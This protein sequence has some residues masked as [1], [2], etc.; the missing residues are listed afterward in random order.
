VRNSQRVFFE[1]SD[2]IRLCG[3]LE[4]NRLDNRAYSIF[5]HCFTCTKDLKAIVRISRRLAENRIAVLRFDFAGLGES[6]G[7]FSDTNFDSNLRDIRAAVEFLIRNFQAPKLL[8]GHSLGGAA[9]MTLAEE[10]ES[11][12]ALIT[13][14][15][16]STTEHLI[17]HLVDAAP[18]VLTDGEGDVAIGN[19][20]WRI[21]R[22]LLE[23]L[24]QYDFPDVLRCLQ[25]PHMIF[26]PAADQTLPYWHAEKMFELT[27]GPKSLVT[28]DGSDHL[29]VDRDDDA[30]FVADMISLWSSRYLK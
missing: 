7:H 4:Q 23:N 12:V 24:K 3:I 10:I 2:G 26:H 17:Q 20:T 28:L 14:A 8:I 13:I 5:S 30:D 18:S 27:G 25:K 6:Q 9:M 19:R 29:L 11:A 22:Q 1:N 21:K 15:A 16:P